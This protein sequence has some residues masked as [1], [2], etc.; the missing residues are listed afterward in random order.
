MNTKKYFRVGF[1]SSLFAMRFRK[2]KVR[3]SGWRRFT[4]SQRIRNAD[5]DVRTRQE[6]YRGVRRQR[7][8]LCLDRILEDVPAISKKN[9][10]LPA[11][12]S[13]VEDLS[14]GFS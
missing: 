1:E 8:F 6:A 14:S 5:R 13:S 2:N 11:K 12:T 9:A 10:E 3:A 4:E 7:A